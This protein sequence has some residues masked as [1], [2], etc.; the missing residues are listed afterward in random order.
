MQEEQI[1]FKAYLNKGNGT[2]WVICLFPH[3]I[4]NLKGSP[5]VSSIAKGNG[6]VMQKCHRRPN[7]FHASDWLSVFTDLEVY[8]CTSGAL[9]CLHWTIGRMNE[10]LNGLHVTIWTENR[11]LRCMHETIQTIGTVRTVETLWP[12]AFRKL[13]VLFSLF[14]LCI[15]N[16]MSQLHVL[17][18]VR[19]TTTKNVFFLLSIYKHANMGT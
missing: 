12:F 15:L 8:Y 6:H 9:I 13:S 16:M 11:T 1:L 19:S 2:I 18:S 17:Y 7:I 5:D 4:N 3:V 10:T 14:T